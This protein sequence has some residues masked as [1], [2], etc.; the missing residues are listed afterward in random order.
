[1]NIFGWEIFKKATPTPKDPTIIVLEKVCEELLSFPANLTF[2]PDTTRDDLWMDSLDD[3][4]LL[5]VVEEEFKIEILDT[6]WEKCNTVADVVT[7]IDSK[8]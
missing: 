4:E 3:F 8:L 2:S 1:M 7:L 5:L 6:E